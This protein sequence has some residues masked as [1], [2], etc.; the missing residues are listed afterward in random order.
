MRSLKGVQTHTMTIYTE[1]KIN[2]ECP[3]TGSECTPRRLKTY[4]LYAEFNSAYRA[5]VFSP[6]EMHSEAVS[7]HFIFYLGLGIYD[8]G[9]CLHSLHFCC[10][11]RWS[12]SVAEWPSMSSAKLMPSQLPPEHF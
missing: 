10:G 3:E 12:S 2:I 7:G 1:A 9:M 11:R 4:A 5:S 6:R 8:H